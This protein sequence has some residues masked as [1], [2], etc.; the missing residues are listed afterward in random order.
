M[1]KFFSFAAIAML[2]SFVGCEKT[3]EFDNKLEF[4]PPTNED[5]YTD[6]SINDAETSLKIMSYNVCVSSSGENAWAD[7]RAGAIE[8]LRQYKPDVFGMQECT[9]YQ[10]EFYASELAADNYKYIAVS[11][12]TGTEDNNGERTALWYNA[13]KY[14]VVDSGT[15]WLAP[16]SNNEFAL[17]PSKGWDAEYLRICTWA[18]FREIDS[19]IEFAV[20]NT[21][22]EYK[23]LSSTTRGAVAREQSLKLIIEHMKGKMRPNRAVFVIGDMNDNYENGLFECLEN[24]E[25]PFLS[26]RQYVIEAYNDYHNNYEN[27]TDEQI[28]EYEDLLHNSYRWNSQTYHGTWMTHHENE[29]V[30]NTNEISSE[31]NYHVID[32]IF[33][34][35]LKKVLS[36]RTIRDQTWETTGLKYISD[37]YP[38]IAEVTF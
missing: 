38:I 8:M 36:F 19:A 1:K 3:D 23:N 10:L 25:V 28:A 32:H 14:E 7:R 30:A 27:L 4:D 33:G 12:D 22:L 2:L 26:T 17:V 35:N 37:H 9:L 21:H 5:A 13:K 11:R 18:V 34:R 31:N 6:I 20:Y 16:K 15:F 29:L 24:E